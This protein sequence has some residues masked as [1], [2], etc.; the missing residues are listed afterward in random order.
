MDSDISVKKIGA[1]VPMSREMMEEAVHWQ[2]MQDDPEY[3]AENLALYEKRE[4]QRRAAMSPL[5]RWREDHPNWWRRFW[6][7]IVH[8]WSETCCE[9]SHD[10]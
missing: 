6:P 1:W 7:W 3:R 2:R 5:G 10:D 8:R 9:R 4:A